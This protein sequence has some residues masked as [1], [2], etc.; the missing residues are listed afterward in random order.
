MRISVYFRTNIVFISDL[1]HI[2]TLLAYISFNGTN[3]WIPY[4]A[5][6]KVQRRAALLLLDEDRRILILARIR[7]KMSLWRGLSREA[8]LWEHGQKLGHECL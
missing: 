8:G 3:V 7:A 1:Y 2:S 5:N 4:Y 6:G